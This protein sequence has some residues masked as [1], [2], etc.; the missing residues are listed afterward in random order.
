M[1]SH[2]LLHHPHHRRHPRGQVHLRHGRAVV[3]HLH[4]SY[5]L[6]RAYSS[7]PWNDCC[8]AGHRNHKCKRHS[9]SNTS[10][11]REVSVADFETGS[12][13]ASRH[14]WPAGLPAKVWSGLQGFLL[15]LNW[16]VGGR[17]REYICDLVF[18]GKERPED[19]AARRRGR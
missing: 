6:A 5:H 19:G 17:Y 18:G 16:T 9:F 11:P 7:C 10:E 1:H 13:T 2:G 15:L 8:W 4:L 3:Q 14:R 12:C